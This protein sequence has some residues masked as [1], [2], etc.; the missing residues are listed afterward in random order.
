[1]R[2]SAE[3][4]YAREQ[5]LIELDR[6]ILFLLQSAGR[7]CRRYL[8]RGRGRQGAGQPLGQAAG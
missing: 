3:L 5:E 7:W 1:V 4:S 2:E 6:R 8:Q